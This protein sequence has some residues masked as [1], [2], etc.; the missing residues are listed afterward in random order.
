MLLLDT[1]HLREFGKASEA[2]QRLFDRMEKSG[3]EVATTIVCIEE[4][5]RG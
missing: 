3:E 2:G 5:A 1:N 4:Q